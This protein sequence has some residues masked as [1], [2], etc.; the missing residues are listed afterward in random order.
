MYIELLL[1]K[2]TKLILGITVN[3]FI[4]LFYFILAKTNNA[5]VQ[6]THFNFNSSL[7]FTGSCCV[8]ISFIYHVYESSINLGFSF[9]KRSIYVLILCKKIS[10]CKLILL[11]H[12]HLFLVVVK[13]L[14][15]RRVIF[16]TKFFSCFSFHN[17]KFDFFFNFSSRSRTQASLIMAFAQPT[18]KG[19]W[20]EEKILGSGGFGQVVLWK[21][22]VNLPYCWMNMRM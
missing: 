5:N 13:L 21:N 8:V 9:L 15:G 17:Y 12:N 19:S 6:S 20:L 22:E 2:W 11:H 16:V 1:S 18:K 14:Q 7:L 3:F 4:I 10:W